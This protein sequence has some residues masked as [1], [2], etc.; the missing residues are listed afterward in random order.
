[1]NDTIWSPGRRLLA[2]FGHWESWVKMGGRPKGRLKVFTCGSFCIESVQADSLPQIQSTAA[3]RMVFCTGHP[4]HPVVLCSFGLKSDNNSA[5]TNPES[6]HH[7]LRFSSPPTP[8]T[9]VNT[10]HN[11]SSSTLL[12][13]SAAHYW[14][15]RRC[16]CSLTRE[17]DPG[18]WRLL[19]PS[20]VFGVYVLPTVPVAGVFS[21]P[22][23]QPWDSSVS[24]PSGWCMSLN[25][26]RASK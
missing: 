2:G 13:T 26:V 11:K 3:V 12:L 20:P 14:S 8:N 10:L 5:M 25:S 24:R 23:M 4:G 19:I 17:Q 7:P 16:G 18:N 15:L 9:F 6:W 21:R 1:M 22:R